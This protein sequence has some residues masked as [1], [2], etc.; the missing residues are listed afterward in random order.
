MLFS[1]FNSGL[2]TKIM[3]AILIAYIVVLLFSLGTHEFAHAYMACR[4]G[5]YTAKHMGRMTMNPFAH[6]DTYGFVCLIVLGFGWAKP[7]PV[8]PEYFNR[9]R[10]SMFQVAIAGIVS[11]LIL[12]LLFACLA[13]AVSTFAPNFFF[14][15]NFWSVLVKHIIMLGMEINL[16][17]AVFNLLPFY[18][19]DGSKILELC[20]K[21]GNKFLDFLKKYSM[22]IMLACLFFG[23]ISYIINICVSFLGTG[24]LVMWG[25]FF[26]IFI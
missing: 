11:N 16:S 15:L 13:G 4:N 5:D 21:P 25:W 1:L 22:L 20:L 23:I 3:I 8:V 17:L 6:F 19:L 7:V 24:M 12:A 2:P 9:G 26:N 10:K 18:P 14:G